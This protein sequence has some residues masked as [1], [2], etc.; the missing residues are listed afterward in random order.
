M[1]NNTEILPPIWLSSH[2]EKSNEIPLSNENFEVRKPISVTL[3]KGWN[4][5]LLKLPVGQFTTSQVRLVKWHFN[6]AFVTLDGKKQIEGL[7]Y[8][9]KLN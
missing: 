3:N 8:K 6:F 9:S 2:T 1:V 5:V 7:V 4:R